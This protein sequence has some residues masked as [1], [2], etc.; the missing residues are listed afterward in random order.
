M[1]QKATTFILGHYRWD[2]S[3]HCLFPHPTTEGENSLTA[4]G[5]RLTNKQQALLCCLL[6]AYPEPL[7]NTDIIKAVWGGDHISAESLPQLI[8]RTRH[9]LSDENKDIIIN[10]PGKGYSLDITHHEVSIVTE[11]AH[12]NAA[13][14]TPA[15][16][17]VKTVSQSETIPSAVIESMMPHET[18]VDKIKAHKVQRIKVAVLFG[19][20]VATL[21]NSWHLYQAHQT[22]A[23][24]E[25]ILFNKP[26]D[27]IE[28]TAITD[29]WRVT[30]G[31]MVCIYKKAD[32]TLDCP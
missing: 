23:Q 26:F 8:N 1:M 9:M 10:H 16:R 28:K 20:T 17:K 7:A 2:K 19:L 22:K 32:Q 24:Y 27:A 25:A 15:D 5:K 3:T 21:W 31:D 18:Q 29:Q 11:E 4:G 13:S 6:D 12:Y 30:I 14:A